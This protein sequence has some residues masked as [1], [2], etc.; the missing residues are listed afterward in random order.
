MYICCILR[1]IASVPTADCL[2]NLNPSSTTVPTG[3]KPS[4]L[5]CKFLFD[6]ETKNVVSSCDITDKALVNLINCFIDPVAQAYSG[7]HACMLRST[8]QLLLIVARLLRERYT[9]TLCM[10]HVQGCG[11]QHV[12]TVRCGT[13][14]H[15]CLHR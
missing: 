7:E 14:T 5:T 13:L 8:D 6:Y 15:T 2:S 9:H 3:T 11:T 12:L 4:D 10:R 1:S